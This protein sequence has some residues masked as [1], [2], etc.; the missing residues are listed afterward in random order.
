[1]TKARI[2]VER[3]RANSLLID[4]ILFGVSRF[5][6]KLLVFLM[7]PLYT[8]VLTTDEFGIADLITTTINFIYPLMTLSIAEATL[9][10]ALMKN[11]S[12][13]TVLC[14]SLVL[15]ALG[16][17]VL[18]FGKPLFAGIDPV[19]EK[20]WGVFVIT[21][22]LSNLQLVFTNFIKGIG[23]TKLFAVQ[24]VLHT[25]AVVVS[26]IILLI[27][28]K[29][30]LNG[31]LL[32]MM[33]GYAI[34]ILYVFVRAK[35]YAYIFPFSLDRKQMKAMLAYSIPMVPTVLAWAVNTSIGKYL[36]IAFIGMS[37]SGIYSAAN[38]IPTLVTTVTNIFLQAWQISAISNSDAGDEGA[39]Y[40]QVYGILNLI[41][42]MACMGIVVL[43]KPFAKILF[44]ETYYSAW[45]CIP[46][47]T[48]AALFSTLS[49]FLAAAYRA[50][51]Q[52]KGLFVSTIVGALVNVAINLLLIREMGIVSA[53]AATAIST[54]VVWGVRAVNVQKLVRV[55]ISLARTLVTYSAVILSA[56]MVTFD[57]S[58]AYIVWALTVVLLAA[59]CRAD[60]MLLMRWILK[61]LR[62]GKKN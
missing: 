37:A 34:P 29:A 35:L 28:L 4:T 38:K 48:L 16:T 31:Y 39:F 50:H 11:A 30:G 25:A 17:L 44:D 7:L 33:I 12:R 10:Y 2:G 36:I 24:G 43:A 49:G 9:R 27:F 6:S 45:Q 5:G 15:V 54:G 32:S 58:G 21:F 1:M 59:A 23:M 8:H 13:R 53:A 62:R 61:L 3:S 57:I 51:M 40:T 14:N 22:A 56:V 26:N 60:I 52:T 46:M 55:Q 42:L 18:S 47:L 20:Y 19:L 41:S